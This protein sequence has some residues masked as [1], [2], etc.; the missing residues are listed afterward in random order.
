[1]L[2]DAHVPALTAGQGVFPASGSRV[3]S[4]WFADDQTIFNQ[5]PDLLT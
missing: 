3:N 4:H 5:F 2:T 1:M